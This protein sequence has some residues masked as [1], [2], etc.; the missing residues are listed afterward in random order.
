MT[1][2]SIVIPT[3]N[4]PDL[5]RACLASVTRHAPAGAEVLVI[6]DGSPG[7]SAGTAAGA[8]SRLRTPARPGGVRG[9][10]LQRV[11]PAGG[12]AA[13]RR[14][15]GVLW[16]VFRGRGSVVPAPARGLPRAVRAGVARAAPCVRLLRQAAAATAG[17]AV[18]Q[19]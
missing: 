13:C 2:L 9:Q 18:V 16:G 15:P 12:A 6:D 8:F 14:L 7:G 10:R 3:H 19:R 4:R 5:L 1:A 11:L 17:A